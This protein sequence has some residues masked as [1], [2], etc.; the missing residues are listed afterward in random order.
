MPLV[1]ADYLIAYL[2]EV[3]P[4][5]AAGGYPAPVSNQELLAWQQT[6]G[7][8]LQP[9]ENRFLRRLSNDYLSQW[10]RSEKPNC[11]EP[12]LEQSGERDMRNVARNLQRTLEAMAKL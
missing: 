12:I 8:E 1:S 6:L 2:F 4:T 11:P 5:V 10:H 9:W 7:I 3:G